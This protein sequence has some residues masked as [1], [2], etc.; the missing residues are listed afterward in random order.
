[1]VERS[2]DVFRYKRLWNHFLEYEAKDFE[3]E[4]GLSVQ[5]IKRI[6]IKKFVTAND[7][8]TAEDVAKW[9]TDVCEVIPCPHCKKD[10]GVLDYTLGLCK[11]C[12]TKYDLGAFY[13]HMS[14]LCGTDAKKSG[15]MLAL[16]LAVPEVRNTYLKQRYKNKR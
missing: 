5:S 13:R 1:M 15:K 8:R 7:W 2:L 12:V 11:R 10:F 9:R 3:E 16:F 6:G 14:D 4:R